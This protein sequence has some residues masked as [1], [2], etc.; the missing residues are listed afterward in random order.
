M[1]YEIRE[2]VQK[3]YLEVKRAGQGHEK[4]ELMASREFGGPN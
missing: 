1:S 4:V 3:A 2:N